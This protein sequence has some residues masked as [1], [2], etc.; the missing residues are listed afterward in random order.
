MD[1]IVVCRGRPYLPSGVPVS[2]VLDLMGDGASIEQITRQLGLAEHDIR[3]CCSFAGR[4][5]RAGTLAL[6][7]I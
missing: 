5:L 7:P 2:R 1:R 4:M 3:A 6:E